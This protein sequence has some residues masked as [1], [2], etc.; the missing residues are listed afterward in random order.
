M[1]KTAVYLVCF[2]SEKRDDFSGCTAQ[3]FA[4]EKAIRNGEWPYDNGDDPSFY[5]AR[6]GG[7]LTWGV[8]RQDVRTS[9][10]RGSIVVFFAYSSIG[11]GIVLYRLCAIATVADKVDHRAL[12]RRP[13]FARSR[14]L[15]I[16][17]LIRPDS[18]GWRYDE[19]NRPRSKRH[20]DWLWRIAD[21]GRMKKEVFRERYGQVYE[22]GWL[23]EKTINNCAPALASNYVVFADTFASAEPPEVA[24]ALNGQHEHWTNEA[25]R[26]L[27]VRIAAARLANHRDYLR[28][29][30]PSGR[31]QYTHHAARSG[32]T[33][34]SCR[35]VD[36]SMVCAG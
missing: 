1:S 23:S 11:H 15:Y 12:H 4:V 14:Q 3:Y 24:R 29:I 7:P 36:Y 28:I 20:E 9:I 32:T 10:S 17:S 2:H 35:W 21:H 22:T 27:T 31:N 6:R 16:N 25:L 8:C 30:N 34:H 26:D 33:S 5:V 13:A 19:T 18:H